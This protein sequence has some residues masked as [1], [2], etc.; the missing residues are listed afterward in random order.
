M[1]AVATKSKVTPFS[2]K[3][4]PSLIERLWPAQ[5][6]SVETKREFDAHGA[7]T[8]TSL[9]SYWK[10]R[11]RLVYVRACVLAA[12]LPATDQPERDLDIFEKLMAIDDRAFLFREVNARPSEI[13]RL[14]IKAGELSED[15]LSNFF[16]V[17]R[18]D[19]PDRDILTAAMNNGALQWRCEEPERNRLR[20]AAYSTW[21]YQEKVDR[22]LRPEELPD[23]AYAGIWREVNAHLGTSANSHAELVEQLGVMRF[24]HR[25]KV[26]DVFCGSGA[27]PFEAARLGCD[28]YASDLNPIACMLTWGAFHLI[29]GGARLKESLEAAQK[30]VADAVE[31]KIAKLGVEHDSHGNRAKAYLYCVEAT[32]P[33]TGW[34]VPLMPSLVISKIRRTIAKLVPNRKHK[35]LDIVVESNVS[36]EELEAAKKGTVQN[37]AMVYELDGVEY[38]TPI[39]ALRGDFRL[40][41]GN[42]GNNLRVWTKS[43]VVPRDDDIFG[44][45]LYCVQWIT[46]ETINKGRQ[47]TFFA[48]PTIA[49]REREALV[50]KFVREHL[51]RWQAAGFIPDM[52]IVPGQ[53]TDEPIRTRGWTYWHHLYCPRQL[54]IGGLFGEEVSN[55]KDDELR[56]CLAFDRTFLADKSARLSQWRLG[57]PGRPGRAPSAD[58]VEHVFYNQALNTFYNF[59]A[60]AFYGLRTGD[61]VTY[62]YSDLSSK[63]AVETRDAT[64]LDVEADVFITDPPYA[65]AV[66]Y[67][68]I[69]EFFIAWLRRNPPSPF[70]NWIW[71]SRRSLA[72]KGSGD[73]FRKAMVSAY[74]AMARCMPENGLQIVMFTHQ[75][76][77]VWADMAQIFWGAGLQV[78]SAWYVSTETTS[79]T[80]KGGYVQGTVTLALRKRRG[81]EVG[82]KD[83]IVQEV[84]VEVADQINT[85]SGLNQTLKGHG[86]IENL[87]EDADLQ[88]AGYAAALRVLTRYAAIDG[89]DMAMEAIRP[90][91]RGERNLVNEVIEFAV[92]VANEHMVPEGM[93]SKTWGKL[94]GAERFYFKMMDI[95]T[96]GA[97]KLDNYQNFAKAFRV[98]AYDD[99]M[100]NME[101]N[102]ATLKTAKQ[103]KKTGFEINEFGPSKSRALLYA[104]CEVEHDV[105]GDEALSHL[106]DQVDGYFNAREDLMA[107]AEYVALKRDKVDDEEARAARIVHGLIRN[108]RF[109]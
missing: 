83:E 102:N 84:K 78:M 38:R 55:V 7:Q 68:E 8:L 17:R 76:P 28:V 1:D 95:E 101:P 51:D 37:G 85:M 3:D 22:C 57:S 14:A 63:T 50:V 34:R 98:P 99:L 9:G 2:L 13:A 15:A 86:R 20:I 47:D 36:A 96:T 48:T 49:D 23:A 59:G 53:K 19:N 109:G 26:A 92:Q 44:E 58:G 60:R 32:C 72:V 5:K 12:L 62:R 6:I 79:E 89:V 29:G 97:K 103:L 77:S 43:D 40:P 81:A 4:A 46:K 105:D 42:T 24:G 30:R 70:A 11:K 65:D 88:M 41:D 106:R 80:K 45:R 71:D 90:Q 93:S 67:H 73:E 31:R 69:T 18:V 33:V 35:R 104:I 94:T 108:E 52:E 27:I 25:P 107:L 87:F 91:G 21:S 54:L 16:S 39:A 56:G 82:Y 61:K 74:S 64:T 10:G 100:G 75:D 66:I